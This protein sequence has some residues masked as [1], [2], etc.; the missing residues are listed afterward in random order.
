MCMG[1]CLL[2]G[3]CIVVLLKCE[4]LFLT[5]TGKGIRMLMFKGGASNLKC[6]CVVGD[7]SSN[8]LRVSLAA[9]F[10]CDVIWLLNIRVQ[11]FEY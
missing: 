10:S 8:F 3:C 6:K 2:M 5:L 7:V 11:N 1:L 4:F 9:T